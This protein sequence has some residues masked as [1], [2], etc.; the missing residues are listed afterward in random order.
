MLVASEIGLGRLEAR[1]C[2]GFCCQT[3]LASVRL[4]VMQGQLNFFRRLS[5]LFSSVAIYNP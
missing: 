5:S 2:F 4:P 1:I 3:N